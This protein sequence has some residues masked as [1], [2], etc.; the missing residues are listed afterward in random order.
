[1]T[2][3]AVKD[4][5]V[6]ADSG[7]SHGDLIYSGYAKIWRKKDDGSIVGV[8][9]DAGLS[10]K[11]QKWAAEGGE[12]P[13]IGNSEEGSAVIVSSD[14]KILVV[15]SHNEPFRPPTAFYALGSGFELA[16]GAM[17][18]G[19]SAQRAVEIACKYDQGSSKPVKALR[20]EAKGKP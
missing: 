2:T 3:I 4:G 11:F 13:V 19:A 20:L 8:A 14:G 6:A 9:G 15:D 16:M 5:I 18:A 10:A 17:A 1:M 7:L 12:R